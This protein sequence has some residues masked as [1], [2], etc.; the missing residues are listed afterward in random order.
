MHAHTARAKV[1]GQSDHMRSYPA[2]SIF[3]VKKLTIYFMMTTNVSV[4]SWDTLF[5]S[6][7]LL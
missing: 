1:P 7:L 2:S 4:V 6:I 3:H 5:V